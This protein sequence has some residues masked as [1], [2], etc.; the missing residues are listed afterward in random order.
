M[1]VRSTYSIRYH[2]I[3]WALSRCNGNLEQVAQRYTLHRD[4]TMLNAF[5]VQWAGAINLIEY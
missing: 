2:F 1:A 4:A 5:Y 3:S